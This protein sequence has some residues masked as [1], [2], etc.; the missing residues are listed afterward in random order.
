MLTEHQEQCRLLAE[1]REL[2]ARPQYRDAGMAFAIP[3]GGH[4]VMKVA[5]QMKSEGVKAGVPDLMLPVARSG[6]HG[7]FIEMKRTK[8][9]KVSQEQKDWISYLD[10]Q[11]YCAVVC[12]GWEAA[13]EVVRGYLDGEKVERSPAV[14]KSAVDFG[15]GED[16]VGAEPV[17]E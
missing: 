15:A 6:W 12:R 2:S 1:L 11:G 5:V 3:N 7:L 16:D 9:G 13:L 14:W 8:G 17:P 4:R 10:A